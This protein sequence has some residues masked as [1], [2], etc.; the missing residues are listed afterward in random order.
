MKQKKKNYPLNLP[1]RLEIIPNPVNASGNVIFVFFSETF[2]PTTGYEIRHTTNLSKYHAL[3]VLRDIE[4]P[5]AG[6]TMLTPAICSLELPLP[7]GYVFPV[8]IAVEDKVTYGKLMASS[9]YFYF[10]IASASGPFIKPAGKMGY[11]RIKPG[12]L[13][14]YVSYPAGY[15]ELAQHLTDSIYHF[16]LAGGAYSPGDYY[17]FTVNS[18]GGLK[19]RDQ[20]FNSI[21]VLGLIPNN[22]TLLRAYLKRARKHYPEVSFYFTTD[23]GLK[24]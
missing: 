15:E 11:S 3:I 2:Y 9:D 4:E 23:K 18:D 24:Y 21:A 14:G 6:L 22:D 20:P 10:E 12:T 16:G 17:Y 7:D 19:M 13:F 1:L 5:L 8:D